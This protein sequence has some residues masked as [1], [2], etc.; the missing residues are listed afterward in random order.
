MDGIHGIVPHWCICFGRTYIILS[1]THPAP[2]PHAAQSKHVQVPLLP[3]HAVPGRRPH[4]LVHAEQRVQRLPERIGRACTRRV[5]VSGLGSRHDSARARVTSCVQI[6]YGEGDVQGGS[7]KLISE[8]TA[9]VDLTLVL[10]LRNELLLLLF[11]GLSSLL[12]LK[13]E[14]LLLLLLLRGEGATEALVD[15]W[16]VVHG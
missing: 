2:Q 14:E 16:E 7:A 8:S 10:T 1:Y 15:E 9:P 5:W 11:S 6:Q 13:L 3:P 12:V 4:V